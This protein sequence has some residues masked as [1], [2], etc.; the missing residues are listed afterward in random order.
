MMLRALKLVN[1][2]CRSAT[3]LVS[4]AQDRPLDGL[5]RVGLKIHLLG[6]RNCR[7]YRQQ[8]QVLDELTKP[9]NES[10][11]QSQLLTPE[12]RRRIQQ[13]LNGA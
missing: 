5:E 9:A 7:R 2:N 10:V 11:P 3:R 13:R 4:E 12:A 1:Q 6:C 8:V